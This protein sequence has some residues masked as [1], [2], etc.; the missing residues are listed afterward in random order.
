MG[1]SLSQSEFE[2]ESLCL[3]MKHIA[4][5]TDDGKTRLGGALG[6]NLKQVLGDHVQIKTYTF[7]QL[8]PGDRIE[9]DLALVMLKR[10]VMELRKFVFEG[11]KVLVVRR[12]FQERLVYRLFTIPPG[13]RVLV[14]NNSPEMTLETV[15]LLQQLAINHLQFVPYHPDTDFRDIRIA[16]NSR[17]TGI[18]PQTH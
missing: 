4:I 17:G 9:M 5:V 14:V 13:T 8:R 15:A 3:P 6:R 18:G 1:R 16:I 2:P 10:K 7:D 12:T 11:Q